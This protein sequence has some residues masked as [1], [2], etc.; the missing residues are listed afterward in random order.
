MT[1]PSLEVASS[2][3]TPSVRKIGISGTVDPSNL[4]LLKNAIDD[5]FKKG[6]YKLVIDLKGAN[7]ISSAGIACFIT[8]L[9]VATDNGGQMIF[10][11]APPQVQRIAE[12][13]MLSDVF[14]FAD[15][16]KSALAMLSK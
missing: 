2:D 6:I 14:S 4:L 5:S 1:G 15:D 13:L 7:Y 10:I 11:A 12:I 3:L 16:E 8:S 9:D